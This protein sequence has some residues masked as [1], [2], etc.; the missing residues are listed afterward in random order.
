MQRV[1]D[2]EKTQIEFVEDNS[3]Q[4]SEIRQESKAGIKSLSDEFDRKLNDD[5][6]KLRIEVDTATTNV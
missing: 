5:I 1:E 4:H 2:L 3:R 6:T